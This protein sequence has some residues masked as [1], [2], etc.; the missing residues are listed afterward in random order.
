MCEG[1]LEPMK[2]LKAS[3]SVNFQ[4]LTEEGIPFLILFHHPDDSDTPSRFRTV[5]ASEL[6]SHKSQLS[7][8]LVVYKNVYNFLALISWISSV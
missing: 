2:L 3:L 5:V 7:A 1:R 4:E 6:M 8:G